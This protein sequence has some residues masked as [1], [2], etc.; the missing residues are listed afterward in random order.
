[1]TR[2]YSFNLTG[3]PEDIQTF[4]DIVSKRRLKD[5]N[6]YTLFT[7][8][9]NWSGAAAFMGGDYR[10]DHFATAYVQASDN[11]VSKESWDLLESLLKRLGYI[12][13][14]ILQN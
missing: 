10:S 9:I 6:S 8:V 14:I 13:M 4:V 5:R 2:A 3:K 7:K 12:K 1:M 11:K